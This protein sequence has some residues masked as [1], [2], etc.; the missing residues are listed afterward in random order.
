MLRLR[1]TSGLILGLLLGVPAGTLTGLLLFPTHPTDQNVSTS[2]Q[3]EELTRKLEF[4]KEQ[5]EHVD[6]QLEQFTKL[7]DQMTASF[8]TLEQRFKA[9]EAAESLHAEPHEAPPATR[10]PAPGASAPAPAGDR[11]PADTEPPPGAP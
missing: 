9:L 4:A 11:E 3:I 5:K 6:R 7:A 1:F 10:V 8:T 2:V